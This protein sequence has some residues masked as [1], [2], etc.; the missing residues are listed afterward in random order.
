MKTEQG[1]CPVCGNELTNR[2]P[3]EA[4]D[5]EL[6]RGWHCLHCQLDGHE[7]YQLSFVEQVIEVEPGFKYGAF[8]RLLRK[9]DNIKQKELARKLC[10]SVRQLRRYEHDTTHMRLNR[11]A[12]IMYI[13]G[14]AVK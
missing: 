2:G 1:K 14:I 10:I 11:F 8:V 4:K 7:V 3:G 9:R 12:A 13:F 5:N 6:T